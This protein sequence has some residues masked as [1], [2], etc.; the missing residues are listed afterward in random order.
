MVVSPAHAEKLVERK[1]LTPTLVELK[2]RK[3]QRV[4]IEDA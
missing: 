3:S 1:P 4:Q 2:N